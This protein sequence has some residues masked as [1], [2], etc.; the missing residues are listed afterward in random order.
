[1]LDL[2]GIKTRQRAAL[3]SPG[4]DEDGYCVRCG[5]PREEGI[6]DEDHECPAGFCNECDPRL[7]T[8]DV[9]ALIAEVEA[10]RAERE[11]LDDAIRAYGSAAC[12]G[13]VKIRRGI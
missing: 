2:D 7:I 3:R 11:R 6:P 10:L 12:R 8:E 4:W 5:L 9:P 13:D 1:M